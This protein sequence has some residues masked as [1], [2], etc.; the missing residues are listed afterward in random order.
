ITVNPVERVPLHVTGDGAQLRVVEIR[1][2]HNDGNESEHTTGAQSSMSADSSRKEFTALHSQ[3]FSM[4]RQVSN[5]FNEVLHSRAESQR[6][7]K[8]TPCRTA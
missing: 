2:G 6:N 1:D 4:Q 8:K 5:L 3:R 7:H